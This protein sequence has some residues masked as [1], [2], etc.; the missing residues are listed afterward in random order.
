MRTQSVAVVWAVSVIALFLAG[1]RSAAAQHM[2]SEVRVLAGLGMGVYQAND[3]GGAG[4]GLGATVMLERD[5]AP[6]VRF[7][8]RLRR[9]RQSSFATAVSPVRQIRLAATWAPFL[10]KC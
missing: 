9:S 3:Q 5:L 4:K 7:G 8:D 6:H 2:H 10:T 1:A